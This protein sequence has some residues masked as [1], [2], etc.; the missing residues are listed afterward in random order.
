MNNEKMIG[1][2][3]LFPKWPK[4]PKNGVQNVVFFTLRAQ[5][6]FDTIGETHIF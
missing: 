2:R 1:L 4:P 5:T 3:K 6:K